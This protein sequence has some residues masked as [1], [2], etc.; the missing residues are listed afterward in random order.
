MYLPTLLI[1]LFKVPNKH[2][3]FP[4]DA[5]IFFPRTVVDLADAKV[6]GEGK[7]FVFLGFLYSPFHQLNALVSFYG[8]S[9]GKGKNFA[10]KGKIHHRKSLVCNEIGN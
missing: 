1:L 4:S 10:E 2:G 9:K 8:Y 6:K 5:D 7:H 3:V